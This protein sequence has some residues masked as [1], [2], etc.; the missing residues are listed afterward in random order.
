MPREVPAAACFDTVGA[1]P[2]R[3][4]R[5]AGSRTSSRDKSVGDAAAPCSARMPLSRHLA[6]ISGGASGLGRAA[7]TH[8]VRRGA[9]V[10]ITDRNADAAAAVVD[11]LGEKHAAFCAADI[12]DAAAVG[13]A[14][15]LAEAKF[16]EPITAAVNTAGILHAAKTISRKGKPHALEPFEQVMRVNV[17]Q[18]PRTCAAPHLAARLA[19][20]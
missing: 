7:A 2:R 15:D 18:R 17:R 5:A 4:G 12:T 20:Q 6:L 16:G 14:L 9:R 11:E 1:A 3:N 13:A 8:L 10:V 19:P